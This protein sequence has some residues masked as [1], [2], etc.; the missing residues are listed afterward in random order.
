MNLI[1]QFLD[2]MPST[3]I[4][5]RN[6]TV[7]LHWTAVCGNKCGLASTMA[8][9]IQHKHLPARMV[10]EQEKNN[11]QT[12]AEWVLS[13]NLLEAGIGMAAL[14]AALE[15]NTETAQPLNASAF[16]LERG[17]QAN[18][19]V[20]GHFP[21]VKRLK[22]IAKNCWVLEKRDIAGDLPAS[23]APD[24]LPKCDLVAIS[25]TALINHS[26]ESILKL[27]PPSAYTIVLGP[28]TPLNPIWLKNGVNTYSGT[29]VTDETQTLA[30]V[31]QGATFKQIAGTQL[32]SFTK[33]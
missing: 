10:G 16:I 15:V 7:G 24:I 1:R 13:D 25:G 6:V 8:G 19:A 21:F 4:P 12:L 2:Q 32:V 17:H 3:P 31:R 30:C 29:I 20:I 14:N 18:V 33:D 22:E 5:T 23:A 11:L 26:L 28:S 9:E 27:I